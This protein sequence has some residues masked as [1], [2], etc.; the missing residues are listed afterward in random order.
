MQSVPRRAP[1]RRGGHSGSPRESL[2]AEFFPAKRPLT[3]AAFAFLPHDISHASRT[4]VVSAIGQ[5]ARKTTHVTPP[6]KSVGGGTAV[7]SENLVRGGFSQK[8]APACPALLFRR[9]KPCPHKKAAQERASYTS[10]ILCHP[11]AFHIWRKR[12]ARTAAKSSRKAVSA[13]HTSRHFRFAAPLQGA[14]VVRNA[15]R[16]PLSIYS[17]FARAGIRPWQCAI[18]KKVSKHAGNARLQYAW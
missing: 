5:L 4:G 1:R 10:F 2:C 13:L 18:G 15:Y 14:S 17:T 8:N 6:G 12:T 3:H 9:Q 16:P 7:L 11:V